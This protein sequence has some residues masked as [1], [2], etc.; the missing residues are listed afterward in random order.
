MP[1][2]LDEHSSPSSILGPNDDDPAMMMMENEG[3]LPFSTMFAADGHHHQQQCDKRCREVQ[4]KLEFAL[5][6][7]QRQQKQ[8][9]SQWGDWMGTERM[10]DDADNMVM[11]GPTAG[12]FQAKSYHDA[13]SHIKTAQ[14]FQWDLMAAARESCTRGETVAV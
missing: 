5:G 7:Q 4:T 11:L 1:E 12:D 14:E 2:N 9:H 10:D 8:Q 3:N 6:Q 13:N